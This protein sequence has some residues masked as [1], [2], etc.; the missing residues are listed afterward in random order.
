MKKT[1]ANK[2]YPAFSEVVEPAFA[3]IIGVMYCRF[4]GVCEGGG[5]KVEA[6]YDL[7]AAAQAIST[8]TIILGTTTHASIAIGNE[9]QRIAN[10]IKAEIGIDPILDK[11]LSLVKFQ[12]EGFANWLKLY[13][14]R[15][16]ANHEIDV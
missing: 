13:A 3:H 11:G 14:E 16:E 6:A 9:K 15:Q 2:R 4:C 12:P 7:W 10:L 5:D 8:L 1:E